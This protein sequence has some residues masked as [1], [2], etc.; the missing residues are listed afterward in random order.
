MCETFYYF[1]FN[2]RWIVRIIRKLCITLLSYLYFM[3]ALSSK[4]VAKYGIKWGLYE[5][6]P[7]PAVLVLHPS[8]NISLCLSW[9]IA[10]VWPGP[11]DDSEDEDSGGSSILCKTIKFRDFRKLCAPWKSSKKGIII[12][13]PAHFR[14]EIEKRIP[15]KTVY[16]GGLLGPNCSTGLGQKQ[17]RKIG[18]NLNEYLGLSL[19][20]DIST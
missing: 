8:W 17:H 5:I 2:S 20:G 18:A 16:E 19:G 13:F 11:S 4:F 14:K 15:K 10:K 1:L 7:T 6:F 3:R 9:V 12:Q